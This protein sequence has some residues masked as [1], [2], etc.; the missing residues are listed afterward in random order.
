[1]KIR[2]VSIGLVGIQRRGHCIGEIKQEKIGP[3][4]W[5]E[6]RCDP[7]AELNLSRTLRSPTFIF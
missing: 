3:F 7:L 5:S 2:D 1:M 6:S 4:V